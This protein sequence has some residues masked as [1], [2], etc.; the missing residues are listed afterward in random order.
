MLPD[1]K[2]DSLE[3]FRRPL[4]LLSSAQNLAFCFVD[5]PN[6]LLAGG[7]AEVGCFH[8]RVV[9]GFDSAGDVDWCVVAGRAA[10]GG[11]GA[12]VGT[13]AFGGHCDG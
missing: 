2:E 1:R 13:G 12:A 11:C 6:D 3:K 8:I 9:A 5:G 7:T 4:K 10:L